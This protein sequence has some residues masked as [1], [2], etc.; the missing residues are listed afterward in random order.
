MYGRKYNKVL[1]VILILIIVAII[2]LLGYLAFNYFTNKNTQNGASEYVDAFDQTIATEAPTDGSEASESPENDEALN[3]VETGNSESSSK[4]A[5][6]VTTYK[7]FEVLGT[8]KIKEP[9][10]NIKYPVLAKLSDKALKT[11]VVAVYPSPTTLNTVG[12]VVIQGHNYRN[13]TFFSDL[14]KLSVG[15][16]IYITDLNGKE[17]EYK[18]YNIFEASETDT[19]FYNRDTDGAMEITLSTC[20]DDSKARTIIEARADAN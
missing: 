7:G 10:V 18:I 19:S 6:T 14:K 1:T 17:V 8:I 4:K 16:S 15:D 5:T 12:N 9:G 20:T 2:A 13:G 11:A 3:T